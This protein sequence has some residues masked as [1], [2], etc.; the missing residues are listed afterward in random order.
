[1][2]K[3]TGLFRCYIS[4]VENGHTIPSI[5]TLEK[6]AGALMVP[7][8]Q[9][10]YQGEEPPQPP[11][12]SIKKDEELWGNSKR[13]ARHLNRLRRS[14]AKMDETERKILLGLAGRMAQGARS[15]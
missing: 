9:L 15:E 11:E 6:F 2:E 13:E 1:M 12:F 3:R 7:M 14:L 4:R 8:Y 10:L 5:K